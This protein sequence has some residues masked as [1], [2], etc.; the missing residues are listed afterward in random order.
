[1][2]DMNNFITLTHI[3]LSFW[4]IFWID[5]RS[6]RDLERTLSEVAVYGGFVPNAANATN[7][8]VDAALTWLTNLDKSW[9]LIVD[10]AD[11]PEV[12]LK[13]YFPGGDR[14]HV[15]ITTRNV[16]YRELGNIGEDGFFTF[17]SLRHDEAETLLL[18]AAGQKPPY[19]QRMKE[20]ANKISGALGHLALAITVAAGSIRFGW[21]TLY[22]YLDYYKRQAQTTWTR[23]K[24][25]PTTETAESA[26]WMYEART[27][28]AEIS[29]MY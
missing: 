26:N 5:G 27:F 3:L 4:G 9:L 15:L 25:M 10:N 12:D 23:P 21:C 14:G 17:D 7:A 8:A 28:L 20:A 13:K 1:M 29:L 6:H 18:A 16:A 24:D 22:D 2:N 19:S 11:D